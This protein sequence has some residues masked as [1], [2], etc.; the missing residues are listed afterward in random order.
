MENYQFTKVGR[1]KGKKKQWKY[2]T[3]GRELIT[4]H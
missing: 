2:K 3:A 1:N 4:C